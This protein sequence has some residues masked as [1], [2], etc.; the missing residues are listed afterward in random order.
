MIWD[1]VLLALLGVALVYLLVRLVRAFRRFQRRFDDFSA[2]AG[3]RLLQHSERIDSTLERWHEYDEAY[4]EAVARLEEE[5]G[6]EP[7]RPGRGATLGPSGGS[8]RKPN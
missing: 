5:A 8:F 4:Q 7:Q 2:E 3:Q 1:K 6:G